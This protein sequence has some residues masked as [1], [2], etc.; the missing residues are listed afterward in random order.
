M[1]FSYVSFLKQN[2]VPSPRGYYPQDIEN[3]DIP[4]TSLTARISNKARNRRHTHQ[5]VVKYAYFTPFLA[6]EIGYPSP[7]EA[8][9]TFYR[10]RPR[11]VGKGVTYDP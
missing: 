9:H 1:D 5:G 6:Y 3:D 2:G 7:Q 8:S 4:I 11:R 10:I